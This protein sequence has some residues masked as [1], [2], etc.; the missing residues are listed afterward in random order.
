MINTSCRG[1]QR[2]KRKRKERGTTANS[3]GRRADDKERM[4]REERKDRMKGEGKKTTGTEK[5]QGE[6]KVKSDGETQ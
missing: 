3:C 4:L 5:E 6:I 1:A 2:K